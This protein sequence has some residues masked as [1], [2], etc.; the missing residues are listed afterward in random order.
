MAVGAHGGIGALVEFFR[1]LSIRL[2][3]PSGQKK[4]EKKLF[5]SGKNVAHNRFSSIVTKCNS[6]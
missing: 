3:N 2:I 5:G 4:C 6:I 1:L